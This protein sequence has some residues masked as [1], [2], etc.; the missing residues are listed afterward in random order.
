MNTN[1]RRLGTR[2]CL[3]VAC[4]GAA[5]A[6][7]AAP[8][9]HPRVP[10]NAAGQPIVAED[11]THI[12][13]GP[14]ELRPAP[15]RKSAPKA[16][17]M[18]DP[19]AA[20]GIQQG[21]PSAW[22]F[23]PFGADIGG[24]GL[25]AAKNGSTTEVYATAGMAATFGTGVYWYSLRYDHA[26]A[27]TMNFVS[28]PMPAGIVKLLVAQ[29]G[30]GK[31][32]YI[33]V[34]LQDG[35]V[36]EYDQVSKKLI[37]ARAGDCSGHNGLQ[38]FTTADMNGD[39]EDEYL[40]VCGDSTLI[41]SGSHYTTWSLASV[42]G[43]DIVAAN[44]DSDPA[45]EIATTSGK[46]I[47]GNTHTVQWTWPAGFGVHLR[48]ANLQNGKSYQGL[49]AASGWNVVTAY[50]IGAKVPVWTIGTPQDIGAIAIGDVDGDGVEELLIGDGQWGKV[51]AYN[52][53]SQALKGQINN[54]S[55]GVTNILVADVDGDGTPEL[56]FGAGAQS[57]E[58][59]YLYT[60]RWSTQSIV[61]Q[62]VD[63]EGPFLG[64]VVGDLDG[65]GIPEIVFASNYSESGYSSGRLIVLDSRTLKV[66]AISP[67]IM[68][69]FAWTGLHDLK[70]RALQPGGPLQVLVAADRLYDGQVEAWAFSK[71]N[72]F[73]R[74]FV[75]GT[76]P[77]DAAYY[78]V[79]VAD[80]DGD[81]QLEVLAG[82]GNVVQ[83]FDP[84][85]GALKWSTLAMQGG[86]VTALGVGDFNGDGQVDVVT[87]SQSGYEYVFNGS[88][89][90]VQSVVFGE[91]AAMR[92]LSAGDATPVFVLGGTDGRVGT[93][94]WNGTDYSETDPWKA[95]SVPITGLQVGPS[96]DWWI[97]G[98]G[99]LS[100]FHNHRLVWS[101]ANYGTGM[102]RDV[103]FIAPLGLVM[104]SGANGVY[105][106]KVAAP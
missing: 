77:A 26:G 28:D 21:V 89:H 36:V 103:A 6:A 55:A 37:G 15:A 43:I 8:P 48:T 69:N 7:L 49:I 104:S 5:A 93:W 12:V 68:D 38:A 32:P 101:S 44:L 46:V 54:P 67:P 88:T 57:T 75:N 90:A 25:V 23:A 50:D 74:T 56:L 30:T 61:W 98:G 1:I 42:G 81:G 76:H 83:V 86:P 71:N 73:T 22:K 65:D 31:H 10:L 2:L 17:A 16:V 70:L 100:R 58:A 97:G 95:L 105:A 41:V 4:T 72:K 34:G 24:N 94:S 78:S 13:Y 47:D 27:G 11:G 82:A 18:P 84:A 99:Q 91:T 19:R 62:N 80:I 29:R 35:T 59:D 51:K 45:I 63:L 66:R 20:A 33:V 52:I 96:G 87:Q 14:T 3:S 60:A 9:A 92:V 39:G 79:E 102:G 53:A 40:S 64:S 106:F 85:T